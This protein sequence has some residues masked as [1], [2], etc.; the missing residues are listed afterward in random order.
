[1]HFSARTT[2]HVFV[3]WS[4]KYIAGY[5]SFSKLLLENIVTVIGKVI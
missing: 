4:Q 5:F 2:A 1:M 3:I